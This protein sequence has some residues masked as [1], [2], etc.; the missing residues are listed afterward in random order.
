MCLS[1]FIKILPLTPL[2][3]IIDAPGCGRLREMEL[4]ERVELIGNYK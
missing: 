2:K 3:G 1:A 4:V